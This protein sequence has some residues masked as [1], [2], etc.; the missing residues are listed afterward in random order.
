MMVQQPGVVACLQARCKVR[1]GD[2]M[3]GHTRVHTHTHRASERAS[4]R[5]R[6]FIAKEDFGVAVLFSMS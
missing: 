5:E 3:G 2:I 1:V 4:E 6:C